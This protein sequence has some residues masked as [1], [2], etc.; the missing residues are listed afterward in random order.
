MTAADPRPVDGYARAPVVSASSPAVVSAFR[1]LDLLIERPNGARLSDLAR[2]LG[3]PKSS[4]LRILGTM[5]QIGV[6][7]R[8]ETT[9]N[10]QSGTR[11]LDYAKAPLNSEM[12]LVREFYRVA[13]P[14]HAEFNETVQLAVLSATDVMFIARIDSTKVVRLVTQIGRRL[15]AHATAVGK[16][17][18]AFSEPADVDRI[19][20]AGLPRLTASTITDSAAFRAELDRARQNGYATESE[21]SSPNLSCL[22]APVFGPDGAVRAGMTVCV[23]VSRLT[24][25]QSAP[26]AQAVRSCAQALSGVL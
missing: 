6:V 9:G 5:C 21:E 20:A 11:L 14:M 7:R 17:I 12:D 23:P 4:A 1:L 18:L 13:E 15:P 8:D 25:E 22:S 19:I 3:L 16:A 2:E 10:Y 26:L 24:P